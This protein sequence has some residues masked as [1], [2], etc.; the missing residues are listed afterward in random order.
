MPRSGPG[1]AT[2]VPLRMIW[3]AVGASSPATSRSKVDL[4]QPEGPTMVT[5]SLSATARSVGSSARVG[6]P[7]RTPGKTRERF[8]IT[9]LLKRS[10]RERAAG[11]PT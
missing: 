11:S 2:G 9:S 4:P 7:P 1:P 6:G 10:S 5:K 3:P 8:L